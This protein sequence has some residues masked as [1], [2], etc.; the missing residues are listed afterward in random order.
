MPASIDAE[1]FVLR[2]WRRGDGEVLFARI[3][4]D[5]ARL[6]AWLPWPPYHQCVEDSE[7]YARRMQAKWWTRED[8]AMG[9]WADGL[10]G[11]VGVHVVDWD[12]RRFEIGYWV[13]APFEGRGFVRRGAAIAAALAFELL[14]AGRVEIRHIVGNTRSEAVPRALGFVDEGV[15]RGAIRPPEGVRADVRYWSLT[16]EEYGAA[17]WRLDA[18]QRVFS[19]GVEG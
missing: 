5:R 3:D 4:A 15:L 6:G 7:D 19:G 14:G 18:A 13:G 12:L 11:S 16:P 1:G 17:P 2:P 9:M 10:V 8:F